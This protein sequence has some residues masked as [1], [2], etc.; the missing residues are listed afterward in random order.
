MSWTVYPTST[1]SAIIVDNIARTFKPSEMVL[2]GEATNPI[3]E[4]EEKNIRPKIYYTNPNVTIKGRGKRY[5]KWLNFN[6]V[7]RYMTEVAEKEQCTSILAV[8]PDEFYMYAAYKV[9]KKLN[10]PF[11]TWF[12]NT[13]LDSRTGLS[14]GARF[15]QPRFFNHA[16]INFLMSDGMLEFFQKK[17]PDYVFKTLRHGFEIPEITYT[18]A[19]APAEKIK[20]MYSGSI[21]SSCLEATLRLF[22]VIHENPAYELH[23]YGNEKEI[24]H[25]NIQT[26]KAILHGFVDWE[27]F[28]NSMENYDIML[29]PHGFD[30]ARTEAEYKTIFPTRTIPLLY[31]NRPIL[32]HT[33]KG[34]FITDFLQK[35]NCAE[36]VDIKDKA[37]IRTAIKRLITDKTRRAEIIKNAIKTAKIFD[38]NGVHKQLREMLE[39]PLD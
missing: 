33:P 32:A 28:V 26:G 6:K 39:T 35:N 20:F 23:I 7:V 10:I 36:V 22:E 9:S 18:P 3:S 11:F 2:L 34:A 14:L 16:S 1:G 30:G 5:L 37:A 17:Y 27:V 12:H 38:I 21:N 25:Y 31:S 15:F 19:D 8:F 13:Y 29:L 4:E 24:K